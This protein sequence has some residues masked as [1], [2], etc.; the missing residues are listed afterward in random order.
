MNDP[1]LTAATGFFIS[2]G[3]PARPAQFSM[4]PYT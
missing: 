4:D 2:L 3:R 1:W